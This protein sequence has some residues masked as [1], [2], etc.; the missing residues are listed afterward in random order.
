MS[1]FENILQKYRY[2]LIF[3]GLSLVLILLCF[4]VFFYKKEMT[5]K[6]KFIPVTTPYNQE[7]F[8]KFPKTINPLFEEDVISDE[9]GQKMGRQDLI[10]LFTEEA[11]VEDIS[12]AAKSINGEIIG[13]IGELGIVHI[14]IENSKANS[15]TLDDAIEILEKQKNV[16][17]ASPNL[18]GLDTQDNMEQ[19]PAFREPIKD[20]GELRIHLESI[21]IEDAWD[22]MPQAKTKIAVIDTGLDQYQ[23]DLKGHNFEL[24]GPL[25]AGS[26]HGTHVMGIVAARKNNKGSVGACPTCNVYAINFEGNNPS[27]SKNFYPSILTTTYA[28]LQAEE[29]DVQVVNISLAFFN[30][31]AF[32]KSLDGKIVF[33][34][35]A[36]GNAIK[37]HLSNTNKILSLPIKISEFSGKKLLWVFAAGNDSVDAK[38]NSPSALGFDFP[39]STLTVGS[40]NYDNKISDFSNFGIAVN[41][42]A[43]GEDIYS[44]LSGDRFGY[45][46]GT[47]MAAPI[48]SGVAGLVFAKYPEKTV[49]EVR[50]CILNSAV[51]N[52]KINALNALECKPVTNKDIELK[53]PFS[54]SRSSG[55]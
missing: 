18:V 7:V 15:K 55:N 16:N 46:S 30:K 42:Y 31:K 11:S 43:P 32:S 39:N 37:K 28:M 47:S 49:S 20:E 50:M 26:D 5:E 12:N 19:M 25:Y 44:T 40:V 10:V 45:K 9:N 23:T 34:E 21:N 22:L 27:K 51:Q 52:I 48:V 1:K 36:Y 6:L 24:A 2:I 3:L 13:V 41:A 17:I 38:L 54:Q 35:K 8:N 53:P 14:R 29:L 4:F 33:D